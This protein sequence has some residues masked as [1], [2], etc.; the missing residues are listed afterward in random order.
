LLKVITNERPVELLIHGQ[1]LLPKNYAF[2]HL[3]ELVKLKGITKELLVFIGQLFKD[4]RCQAG[5]KRVVATITL[6]V[7][8]Q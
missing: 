3:Q 4:F 8:S 5:D 6:G 1:L 2:E 7:K